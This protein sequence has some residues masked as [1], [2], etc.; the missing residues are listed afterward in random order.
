MHTRVHMLV[1]GLVQG[2]GFRWFVARHA[3]ALG[4]RGYV[5]NLYNGSVEIEAAGDR[6]L[7]EQFIKEI[8]VGPRS[9]HVTDLHVEWRDPIPPGTASQPPGFEI[10]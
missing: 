8:K 2:V 9:A 4:L 10:R 6:S 3:E 7:L 5:A 1:E